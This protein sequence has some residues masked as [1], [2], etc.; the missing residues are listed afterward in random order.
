MRIHLTLLILL[1]SLAT[2]CTEHSSSSE[3][4]AAPAVE[5]AATAAAPPTTGVETVSPRYLTRANVLETSGKVQFDEEHLVRV[6]APVTGRV[7]E[8]LARP[9][10]VVEPGHR[11][12]VLDSPDLGAVKTDYLK[13][14]ADVE[15]AEKALRLVRELYDVKAI[16][17][18]DVREAENDAK[19]AVAERERTR[20]RLRTLGIGDERL[21][22]IS[23]RTDSGT[24]IDVVAPR[25]GVIVERNVTPGQ[26]VSYGASDTPVNL[27]VIA[28]LSRMW[29][30]ADVYEPDIP[31]VSLGQAVSVTLPCCPG[32]HYDGKATYISDSVDKETRT[33][34]VRAVVP[35]RGRQLKAEMFV[36]VAIGT[37]STRALTVPQSAVHR[38]DGAPFVL[39]ARG[40]DRYERRLVKLGTELDG[41][42]EVLSGVTPNDRVVSA[43]SILLKRVVK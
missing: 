19:K 24:R 23:E 35:N 11:L 16:P 27:F 8:V 22:E 2:G 30:L 34:K 5:K 41:S 38:E 36:R 3:P 4:A 7:V 12:L 40:N 32:Q 21:P 25:S 15:R 33:V 18:K 13:A 26:V 28:D 37:G 42:I 39:V 17:Q 20:S 9:G 29:V 6:H 14:L 43:G 31:R 10:D 1:A